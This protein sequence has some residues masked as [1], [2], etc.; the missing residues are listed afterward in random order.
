MVVRYHLS[1][2]SFVFLIFSAFHQP[3]VTPGTGSWVSGM[4]TA[5]E[6]SDPHTET[7][8]EMRPAIG[9]ERRQA[10][11]K[12]DN[13]M[14]DTET[15]MATL[16]PPASLSWHQH[17]SWV[18][19]EQLSQLTDKRFLIY[20]ISAAELLIN[21]CTGGSS[22]DRRK[23][24]RRSFLLVSCPLGPGCP[25]STTQSRSHQITFLSQSLSPISV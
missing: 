4:M 20:G 7:R 5:E 15:V 16:N 2:H 14:A 1:N 6:E 21:I 12:A 8:P 23:E 24:S 3:S 19:G 25:V 10:D 13:T 18:E 9:S 11:I 22:L 17:D